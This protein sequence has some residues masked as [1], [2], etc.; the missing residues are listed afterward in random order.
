MGSDDWQL[1]ILILCVLCLVIQSSRTLETPLLCPW[2]SPGKNTGV[3]CHFLL[4]GIVLTQES[5]SGLLHCRRI[6]YQL[7]LVKVNT[8]YILQVRIGKQKGGQGFTAIRA[9]KTP[10]VC[11]TLRSNHF[12]NGIQNNG[13]KQND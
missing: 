3:G 11:L 5:N 1:R 13:F 7:E 12:L 9:R 4:Q 2:D 6:L 10:Q 8:N